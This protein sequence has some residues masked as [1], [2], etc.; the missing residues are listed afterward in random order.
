MSGYYTNG[1]PA[2]VVPLTGLETIPMDTNI[3]AGGGNETVSISA[4][5]LASG[6]TGTVALTDAA[7]IATNA[8]LGRFFIVTLGGNRTLANPT[9]LIAGQ[10]VI[11][12]IAQDSSGNRTLAFGN[13][14]TFSGSSTVSVTASAVDVIRAL[15]DGTKLRA[16]L[17]KA[18]A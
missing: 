9:G 3:T 17:S 12:E 16:I 4:T 1:L 13:L 6:G 14:F 2:A 11:W 8:A 15:Y 10:E 18:Y 5:Q 7:S